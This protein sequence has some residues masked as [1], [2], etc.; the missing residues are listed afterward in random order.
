[1][2]LKALS[3]YSKRANGLAELMNLNVLNKMCTTPNIADIEKLSWEELLLQ[4]PYLQSRTVTSI[5]DMESLRE[6]LLGSASKYSEVRIFGYVACANKHA[7]QTTDKL[8]DGTIL[9]YT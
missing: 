3:G 9:E 6:V 5:L 1:M 2:Q 8:D 7:T 4:V